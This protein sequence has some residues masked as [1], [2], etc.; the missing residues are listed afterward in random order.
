MDNRNHLLSPLRRKKTCLTVE[1]SVFTQRFRNEML[2]ET[3]LTREFINSRKNLIDR[4]STMSFSS[5][6][7]F[8]FPLLLFHSLIVPFVF[9]FRDVEEKQKQRNCLTRKVLF[10]KLFLF[11]M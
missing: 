3:I 8:Y 7:R 2:H 5:N 10:Y 9:S 6:I 4:I 1:R 11:G